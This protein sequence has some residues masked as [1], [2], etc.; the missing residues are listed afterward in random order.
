MSL[1]EVQV[2][3]ARTSDLRRINRHINWYRANLPAPDAITEED[4]WPS[5]SARLEIPAMLIWGEDDTVFDPAFIEL[6][7]QTSSDLQVVRLEGV[8]HAPQFEASG[9]VNAA[10]QAHIEKHQGN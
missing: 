5:R 4:F 7:E 6:V 10:L 9:A 3:M 8:G 2:L 1:E